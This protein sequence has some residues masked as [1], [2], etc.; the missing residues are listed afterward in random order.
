MSYLSLCDFV[1]LGIKYSRSVNS[2]YC[3][4]HLDKGT[5]SLRFTF[6]K[7]RMPKSPSPGGRQLCAFP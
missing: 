6:Q 7:I 2:M 4:C 1:T 3:L 5:A